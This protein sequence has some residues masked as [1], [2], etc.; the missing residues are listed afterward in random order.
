LIDLLRM[1][2]PVV[3]DTVGQNVEYIR[4]NETGLLVPSGDVPA[5]ADAVVTLLEDRARARMLGQAAALDVRTR[6][7][8]NRLIEAVQRVYKG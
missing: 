5:M 4:H 1:G 2:V 6:F 8:W 3:A 7:G